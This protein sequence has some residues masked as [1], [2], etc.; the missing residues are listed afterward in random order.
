[1]TI[2]YDITYLEICCRLYFHDAG[3]W[4]LEN[5]RFPYLLWV[6]SYRDQ[7]HELHVVIIFVTLSNLKIVAYCL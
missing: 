2:D 1:M 6:H 3:V 4:C 7:G 5:H